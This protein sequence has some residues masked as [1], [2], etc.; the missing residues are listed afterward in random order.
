MTYC[1]PVLMQHKE[2]DSFDRLFL[3]PDLQIGFS[4]HIP[5]DGIS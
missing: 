3:K 1:Q 5:P 4:M 2:K